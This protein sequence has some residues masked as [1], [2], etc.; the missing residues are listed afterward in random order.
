MDK[1]Y[2]SALV[3]WKLRISGVSL[4]NGRDSHT[5]ITVINNY[6]FYLYFMFKPL[7]LKVAN[8]Q[9]KIISILI[10]IFGMITLVGA[11]LLNCASNVS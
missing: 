3:D 7:S 11:L 8:N 2:L 9:R 10:L 5:F 4:P 1:L 6:L